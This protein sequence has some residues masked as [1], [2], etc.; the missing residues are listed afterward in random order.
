MVDGVSQIG[1]VANSQVA[2]TAT[3]KIAQAIEFAAVADTPRR[4][5]VKSFIED[6]AASSLDPVEKAAVIWNAKKIVREHANQTDIANRALA[7]LT[8]KARPDEVD[9]SWIDLFFDEARTVSDE[10]LKELWAHLLT[11]EMEEPG[12]IPRRVFHVLKYMD[13]AD[14]EAFAALCGF[15]VEVHGSDESRELTPMVLGSLID[16]YYADH[17]LTRDALTNLAT[18]GLIVFPTSIVNDGGYVLHMGCKCHATYGGDLFDFPASY[19]HVACGAVTFTSMGATLA[20]FLDRQPVPG[21]FKEKCVPFWERNI[22][23]GNDVLGLSI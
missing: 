4:L 8:D 15:C 3:S 20:S 11:G 2:K 21:F 17:G 6:V 13:K 18:W 19:E 9:D 14:A 23:T 22:A 1:V 16:S 10:E 12:S 5:A 7:Q